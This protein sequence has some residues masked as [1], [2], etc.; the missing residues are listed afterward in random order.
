MEMEMS[1]VNSVSSN[2]YL[3]TVMQATKRNTVS[4][5]LDAKQSGTPVDVKEIQSSNQQLQANA[6]DVRVELYTRE[7]KLNTLNTYTEGAQQANDMY[8][9][10]NNDN[11]SSEIESFNASNVN[12]ARQTAQE[13]ALKVAYY[14]NISEAASQLPESGN[15]SP[16]GRADVYV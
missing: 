3:N 13:R 16:L 15:S 14:E 7:V 6:K 9:S 10:G 12:D 1:T 4:Q 11:N 5:V 2:N 8:S